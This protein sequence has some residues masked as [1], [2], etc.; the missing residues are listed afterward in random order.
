MLKVQ[1]VIGHRA[2]GWQH[3]VVRKHEFDLREAAATFMRIPCR[4]GRVRHAR[5][6]LVGASPFHVVIF[7]L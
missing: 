7:Y 6:G 3:A 4:V 1:I 2:L 5:L